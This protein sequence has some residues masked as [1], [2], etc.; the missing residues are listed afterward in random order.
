MTHLG[1]LESQLKTSPDGG[2]FLCGSKLTAADILMSYPMEAAQDRSGLTKE[3]YPRVWAYVD[4][5]HENEAYKRSVRKIEE[6]EGSF[7][8]HL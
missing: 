6:V 2:K 3:Q 7:K 1:F 5:L 8:T 4:H